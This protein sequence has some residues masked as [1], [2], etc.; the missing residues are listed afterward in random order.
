MKVR[1]RFGQMSWLGS[2]IP[3]AVLV[4]AA[5]FSQAAPAQSAYEDEL[6]EHGSTLRS[7]M[8]QGEK[9]RAGTPEAAEVLEKLFELSKRLHRLEEEAYATAVKVQQS[10]GK[11]EA[12][13]YRVVAVAKAMDL[14]Q[15]LTGFY[16]ETRDR[17][18]LAEANR[19][20]QSARTMMAAR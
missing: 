4:L 16:M 5:L 10:T 19:A 9:L 3:V 2:R 1:A 18:M 11:A 12:A 17:V 6:R 20:A 14:A 8:I 7:L 15:Q 13:L